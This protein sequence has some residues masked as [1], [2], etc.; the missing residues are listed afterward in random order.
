[1]ALPCIEDIFPLDLK[2][3]RA[4]QIRCQ[5]QTFLL[6]L[7]TTVFL[8]VCVLVGIVFCTTAQG[9]YTPVHIFVKCC[10]A[11]MF[12][13]ITLNSLYISCWRV[14]KTSIRHNFTVEL[15]GLME[16]EVLTLGCSFI[17]YYYCLFCIV[18]IET[19][20]CLFRFA[21]ACAS[22]LRESFYRDKLSS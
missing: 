15:T 8:T 1:M 4:R 19:L 3:S 6:C 13:T 12:K 16:W 18:G 9:A 5:F 17:L 14:N 11:C 7:F 2:N 21:L 22:L 10:A 20:W